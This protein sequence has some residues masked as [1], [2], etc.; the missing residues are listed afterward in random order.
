MQFKSVPILA[1]VLLLPFAVAATPY[2]PRPALSATG[3]L[4]L[5]SAAKKGKSMVAEPSTAVVG[6]PAYPNSEFVSA[7]LGGKS[8]GGTVLPTV[9]LVTDDSPHQVHTWYKNHLHGWTWDSNFDLFVQGK[10]G[11]K[12]FS[13]LF[14][15]PHVFVQQTSMNDPEY[16]NYVVR[17]VRTRIEIAYRPQ[18][19]KN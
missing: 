14:D 8:A 3:K 6:V 18:D 11:L 19:K 2:A 9:V 16:D 15:T 10:S 7:S 5:K 17:G 4:Y 1:L 12:S 13:R